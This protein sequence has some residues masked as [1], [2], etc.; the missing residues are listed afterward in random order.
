MHV[1]MQGCI[2]VVVHTHSAM[3][4]YIANLKGHCASLTEAIPSLTPHL[5]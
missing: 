3:H 2:I 4:V 1:L 5:T